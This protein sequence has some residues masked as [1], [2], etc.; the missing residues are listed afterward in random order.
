[1]WETEYPPGDALQGMPLRF[2]WQPTHRHDTQ[3]F[4]R[5]SQEE[6]G[7]AKRTEKM[8]IL[9]KFLT[10]VT[11]IETIKRKYPGG[12]DAYVKDNLVGNSY[13]DRHI[14]GV[15]FMSTGEAGEFIEKLVSLGFNYDEVALVDQLSG[16]IFP[17]PWLGASINWYFNRKGKDSTCWL[18]RNNQNK[19]KIKI[20]KGGINDV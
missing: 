3:I 15:L 8:T 4:I 19:S 5:I 6:A 12:L 13:R 1:M 10:V 18:K 20:R 17:C 11:R 7:G 16:K 2:F 14:A 9:V